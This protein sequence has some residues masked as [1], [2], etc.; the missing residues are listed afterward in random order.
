MNSAEAVKIPLVNSDQFATVDA[1]D[2]EFIR[3]FEWFAVCHDG[4]TYA[5]TV[6]RDDEGGEQMIYMHDLIAARAGLFG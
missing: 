2:A 1:D 5:A 6:V 4:A 3:Q